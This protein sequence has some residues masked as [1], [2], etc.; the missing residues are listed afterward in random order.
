[1]KITSIPTLIKE[2]VIL[3]YYIPKISF[4]Y[5]PYRKNFL[6]MFEEDDKKQYYIKEIRQKDKRPRAKHGWEYELH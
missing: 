1:M 4:F 2:N 5:Q 6:Y 3:H